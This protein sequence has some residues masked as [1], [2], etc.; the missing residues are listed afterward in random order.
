MNRHSTCTIAAF[1]TR[2]RSPPQPPG[3]LEADTSPAGRSVHGLIP[4]KHRP[5]RASRSVPLSLGSKLTQLS[6]R[7]APSPVPRPA[8]PAH[9][10]HAPV[11]A[12]RQPSTRS[13]ITG[14]TARRHAPAH[15]HSPHPRPCRTLPCRTSPRHT[16]APP[17]PRPAALA[18]PRPR[19]ATLA[20]PHLALPPEPRPTSTRSVRATVP[21]AGSPSGGSWGDPRRRSGRVRDATM[22]GIAYAG[23]P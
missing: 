18:P 11:P 4:S 8:A 19:P 2:L 7:P 5:R 12:T 21:K 13:S 16:L 6:A 17:H 3:N 9:A 10:S 23:F 15:A 20:L 1:L 14:L 22:G